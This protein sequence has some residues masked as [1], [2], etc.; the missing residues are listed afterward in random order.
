MYFLFNRTALPVFVTYLTDALYVY[1]LWF[2]KHEHENRVHSKLFVACQ[3]WWF[4]CRF[5][6]VP[7]VPG[8]LR[9]EEEHKRKLWEF[10]DPSVQLYT[11]I[12]SVLCVASSIW[13]RNISHNTTIYY[14]IATSG[15]LVS[16]LSS[17]LQALQITDPRLSKCIVHSGIPCAYKMWCN[18]SNSTYHILNCDWNM[19]KN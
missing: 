15:L 6:F 3:R 18:Y 13:I 19:I 17:H 16:T 2:Y 14:I 9:E 4:Q 7:S 10:D 12:S 5:W 1:R 11:A 8:Y